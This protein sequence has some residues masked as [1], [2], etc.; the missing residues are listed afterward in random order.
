[1]ITLKCDKCGEEVAWYSSATLPDKWGYV[2]GKEL[3]GDCWEDYQKFRELFTEF[4]SVSEK[5][6]EKVLSG[7]LLLDSNV[8]PQL[9]VRNKDFLI[10]RTL[11]DPSRKSPLNVNLNTASAFELSSFPG[12][13]LEKAKDIVKRREESGYFKSMEEAEAAGFKIKK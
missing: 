10:R 13:S 2:D 6:I 5:M 11:W 3:C 1:M 8:G 12:I 7:E 9:W 4:K